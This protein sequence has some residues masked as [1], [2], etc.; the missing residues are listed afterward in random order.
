M[1][2][3]ELYALIKKKKKNYFHKYLGLIDVMLNLSI[4]NVDALL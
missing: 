2:K 4:C 3:N 1:H